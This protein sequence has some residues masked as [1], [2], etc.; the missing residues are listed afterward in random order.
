MP[1]TSLDCP[2]GISGLAYICPGNAITEL[3]T[4]PSDNQ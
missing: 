2:D 3:I 1:V 4:F